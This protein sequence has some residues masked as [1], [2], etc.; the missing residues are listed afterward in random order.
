[1]RWPPPA[2]VACVTQNTLSLCRPRL[3]KDAIAGRA[4]GMLVSVS[5]QTY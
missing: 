2:I 4:R 3:S 1:M 5:S